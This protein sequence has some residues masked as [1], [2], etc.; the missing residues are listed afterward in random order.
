MV[1]SRCINRYVSRFI[2][3]LISTLINILLVGFLLGPSGCFHFN[4]WELDKQA[5]PQPA[6]LGLSLRPTV[7]IGFVATYSE[8]QKDQ[9]KAMPC[10]ACMY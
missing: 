10:L 7:D 4:K 3:R 9:T 6:S 5:S 2:W 1:I 8:E